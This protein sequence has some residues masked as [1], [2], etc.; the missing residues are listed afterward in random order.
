MPPNCKPLRVCRFDLTTEPHPPHHFYCI[1]T[2]TSED[3]INIVQLDHEKPESCQRAAREA[4]ELLGELPIDYIINNAAYVCPPFSLFSSFS[5]SLLHVISPPKQ[6]PG[7]S[8]L[9][10]ISLATFQ[11]TLVSNILGPTLVYQTFYR[12]LMKSERPVVANISSGAGS[13]GMDLGASAPT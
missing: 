12:F 10:S 1:M 7:H 3:L 4:E 9:E 13:I 2:A 11:K 8:R 5:N 6:H